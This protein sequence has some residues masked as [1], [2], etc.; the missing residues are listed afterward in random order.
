MRKILQWL[1][2][3]FCIVGLALIGIYFAMSHMG[4]AA[5]FNFGDPAKFQFILVPFWQ[6]GFVI[7][8]VGGAFLL[9][10]RRLSRARD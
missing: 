6:I 4:L 8:V 5:S 1:G 10:S 2:W 3:S 9:A 7:G